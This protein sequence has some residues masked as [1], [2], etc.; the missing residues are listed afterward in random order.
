MSN[1]NKS[2]GATFY[3]RLNR[4]LPC[5]LDVVVEAREEERLALANV[6][7]ML[8]PSATRGGF[9]GPSTSSESR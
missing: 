3:R 4:F 1:F 7:S 8:E 9:T 6:L 5:L 2:H